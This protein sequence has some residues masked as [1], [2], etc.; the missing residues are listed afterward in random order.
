MFNEMVV[1]TQLKLQFECDEAPYVV[2]GWDIN[3]ICNLPDMAPIAITLASVVQYAPSPALHVCWQLGMSLEGHLETA[4][5]AVFAGQPLTHLF[6]RMEEPKSDGMST[7]ERGLHLYRH[8]QAS[9]NLTIFQRGF[10]SFGCDAARVGN[11]SRFNCAFVVPSGV[12][13]WAPPQAPW[14]LYSG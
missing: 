14:S 5:D 3:G 6:L 13:I 8:V 11:L 2:L 1:L 9:R 7:Y 4:A 10:I 12:G